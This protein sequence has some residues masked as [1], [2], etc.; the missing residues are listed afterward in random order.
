MESDPK[1]ASLPV[2]TLSSSKAM[3]LRIGTLVVVFLLLY[4]P[5][6]RDLVG[7]W[8]TRDNYSY[9]FLILPISLYLVWVKR[10]EL[11]QLPLKPGNV[12]GLSLIL[13]AGILLLLGMGGS[14]IVLKGLSFVGMIVGLVLLLLGT[15]YAKALAFPIAY[16]V[17][18]IPIFDE[19][20]APLHWPLQLY[21][22]S[23]A[24]R[25]LQLLG[26]SALV[27]QQY[28]V[29]PRTTLEVARA[30]SGTHYLISILA[31]GLP[32]AYL[33]LRTWWS[34]GAL[35]L[36]A[37]AVGVGAN[38]LRVV[39]IGIWANWGGDVLHGPFEI[40][41]AMFVAWV[42]VLALVAAAWGLSKMQAPTA[43][44]PRM[45]PLPMH[46]RG[47]GE[48]CPPLEW[49]RS[50]HIGLVALIVFGVSMLFLDRG[51][52]QLKEDLATL[53]IS[54]DGWRG[55]QA[56]LKHAIFRIE[57]ADQELLRAYQ[58]HEGRP[59][60]LYVAYLASQGQW[61]KL[62]DYRT[63]RLH[64]DADVVEI[65]IRPG[66]VIAVNRGHLRGPQSEHQVIF[67]YDIDGHIIA[68][69]YRA[70]LETMRDAL[71]HGRTNGAL[72]LI[73]GDSVDDAGT[74]AQMEV[75]TRTLFPRLRSYLP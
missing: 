49:N 46:Q 14:V 64:Q 4:A 36:S 62:V 67:W 3:L 61:K 48:L 15:A 38:W 69:R 59:L 68:D 22:A 7:N 24:V 41:R 66:Q 35:I 29:L 57:G 2:D 50:W 33:T 56:D 45:Q 53:P 34:R 11:A 25:L 55:E 19:V 42:G 8:W 17:F 60:Q 63:A 74:V 54:F 47:A 71:V 26:F 65:T 21:T 32:L 31:I 6:L 72:V 73:A 70:K 5:V 12:W 9:G 58:N 75:F 40:F 39:L 44:N 1:A 43:R 27:E 30:C 18:M 51:P 20:L 52:V 37:V 28:I 13:A 10:S 16:L 23:M